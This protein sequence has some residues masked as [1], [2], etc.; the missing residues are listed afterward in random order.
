[1]RGSVQHHPGPDR[2][3]DLHRPDCQGARF[4]I[5]RRK[6]AEDSG[7]FSRISRM[8]IASILDRR[9]ISGTFQVERLRVG[10]RCWSSVEAGGPLVPDDPE[11][12]SLVDGG[13]SVPRP[14][15]SEGSSGPE[16]GQPGVDRARTQGLERITLGWR[17]AAA[18]EFDRGQS[19]LL[20]KAVA[21]D[22]SVGAGS[23]RR[24]SHNR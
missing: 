7:N 1:M 4:L 15:S 16:I 22:L 3:T 10:D 14:R 21:G 20:Q 5:R 2:P 24:S 13:G 18:C 11:T 17:T 8:P 9:T 19:P 12:G 6:S 23:C